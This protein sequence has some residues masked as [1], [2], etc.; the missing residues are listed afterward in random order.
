MT[1]ENYKAVT[2][3]HRGRP[4]LYSEALAVRICEHLVEGRSLRSIATQDDTP[5][6]RTLFNWLVS[7]KDFRA[8]YDKARELQAEIRADGIFEI[9]EITDRLRQ[10]ILI[11]EAPDKIQD[12]ADKEGRI[13][14]Q[15]AGLQKIKE[16][17]T[18]PE[19]V[20]KKIILDT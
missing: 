16:G 2:M 11:E 13:S 17:V 8:L 1:S 3:R 14:I 18:S 6:E 9:V 7:N 20:I 10:A 5:S 19:E 15:A 12:L 4:T